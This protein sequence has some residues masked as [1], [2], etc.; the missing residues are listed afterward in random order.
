MSGMV[1]DELPSVAITATSRQFCFDGRRLYP[2]CN[3]KECGKAWDVSDIAVGTF[4]TD[5][6]CDGCGRPHSTYPAPDWLIEI[7]PGT[8]V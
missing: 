5:C 3:D 1:P 8:S 6:A 4:A 2:R 7:M